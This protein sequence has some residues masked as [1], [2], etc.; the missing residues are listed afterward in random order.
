[1]KAE[2][3]HEMRFDNVGPDATRYSAVVPGTA[4]NH[5][6]PARYDITRSGTLGISQLSERVLLSPAQVRELLRFLGVKPGRGP[7]PR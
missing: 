5:G 7:A 2:Y 4:R 1:M 6:R 3:Q